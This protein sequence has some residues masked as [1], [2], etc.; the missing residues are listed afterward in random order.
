MTSAFDIE[1]RA[2]GRLRAVATVL[3]AAGI[4]RDSIAILGVALVV[5]IA[6]DS[7]FAVR[8]RVRGRDAATEVQERQP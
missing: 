3:T 4:A 2:S 6:A 8:A 7:S 5:G 1:A